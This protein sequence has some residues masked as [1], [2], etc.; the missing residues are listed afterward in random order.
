[1]IMYLTRKRHQ[2]TKT[3]VIFLISG[4][5]PYPDVRSQDLPN[6]LKQ[7]K[8]N[9]KPEYCDDSY[10]LFGRAYSTSYHICL[11]YFTVNSA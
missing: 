7:N 5:T 8:R 4:E 9:T 1:M 6:W 3:Y 2:Y 11:V 10:V